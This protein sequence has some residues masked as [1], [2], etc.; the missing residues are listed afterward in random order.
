M[1]QLKEYKRRESYKIAKDFFQEMWADNKAS[2]HNKIIMEIGLNTIKDTNLNPDII[3]IAGWLHNLGKLKDSANYGKP[4]KEYMDFFLNKNPQYHKFRK[5]IKDSIYTSAE[6][7][8]PRTPYGEIIRTAHSIINH[9]KDWVKSII[10]IENKE[11][12]AN[13]A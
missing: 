4:S 10:W 9:H 6:H 3:I 11:I 13:F 12:S 7:S 1:Q 8:P 5:E 2:I